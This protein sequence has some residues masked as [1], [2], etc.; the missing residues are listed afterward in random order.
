MIQSALAPEQSLD[1][2][3]PYRR[4]EQTFP[5]LSKD[6]AARVSAFGRI[7]QL[8]AL[9]SLFQRDDRAADFFLIQEGAIEIYDGPVTAPSVITLLQAGQ[10]TGELDL[11]NDR[12]ILV[13]ARMAV[14]GV[15]ARLTRPQFRR[16]LVAEPDI[17]ELV[18]R[19]IILRRMG[20]IAHATGSVVL[21]RARD[22][23]EAD[24]LRIQRFLRRNGY[25]VRLVDAAEAPEETRALLAA[26]G[27]T[28]S[29][30]PVV[31]CG[32]GKALVRPGNRALADCLGIAELLPQDRVFDV[33]VVG[34]G[35]AGLAAAVYAAS[36]GLSTV[37]LEGEAPGGQAGTSSKIEN[38]L[39]FPTGISGQALAGRAQIQA[40]KFG[41]RI[42][43]PRRVVRLDCAERPY[44][45]H[46]EDGDLVRTRAVVIATGARYRGLDGLPE[47]KHFEARGHPLCRDA[48]RGLPVRAGGDRD[49]RWRQLRRTGGRVPLAPRRARA[50]PGARRRTSPPACRTIWSAG[51]RRRTGSPCTPTP[52]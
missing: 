23:A 32:P 15:V 12:R 17:A 48:D 47:L 51:S 50:H 9:A 11:F 30:L 34:A 37:V 52:R 46:L 18:M 29:D 19:A 41:A 22:E 21:I 14:D 3:D 40:Q 24:T 25:P 8:P 38:Y 27:L 39:G 16:M 4:Y 36:E 31:L 45:L 33:T 44:A 49:R 13:S 28:M 26:S 10:F 35:P 5:T 2:A 7:E 6:Q 42:A 1:P 20:L 43:V